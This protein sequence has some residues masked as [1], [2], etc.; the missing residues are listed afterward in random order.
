MQIWNQFKHVWR[1][2]DSHE[3]SFSQARLET[4][5]ENELIMIM[6]MIISLSLGSEA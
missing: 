5:I 1:L 4:K 3:S 6:I 2:D